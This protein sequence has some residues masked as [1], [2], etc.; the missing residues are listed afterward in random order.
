[1]N[2]RMI[3]YTVG[4]IAIVEAALMLLPAVVSLIYLEKSGFSFLITAAIALVLGFLLT[5]F[6]PK[7]TSIYAKE[8]FSIVAYAW[9]LM[10][11][12]GALP[13]VISGFVP[14]YID[15]FFETVSG[16]T[17]TGASILTDVEALDKGLLFWRSFT[18]WIGGMGV[19]VLVTA[20]V[21]NIG[22]RSINILK[23]EMPGPTVGKL[24]PRSRDTAKVLYIIYIALTFIQIIL[25]RVGGMP[26]YDSIVHTFGTAGTGG[27]GIKNNSIA[28]YSP[29]LQW[30]ITVFMLLFSINFNLYYLLLIRKF[31]TVFKSDELRFFLVMVL[32]CIAIVTVNIAP[33]YPSASEALRHSAFQVSSIVSTTGY[34]TTDFDL[35]PG[36]SKSILMLLMV[37]GACAGSTGGGLKA[38]RVVIL[39][40][41]VGRELQKLLHPRSVKTVSTEGKKLDDTTLNGVNSYFSI[42]IICIVVIYILLS[43]EPFD[44]ETN[45]SA[46]LACFNNIGPGLGKVGPTTNYAAY[47]GFSKILLSFAMLLGRLEIFPLLL[48]LNPFIWKSKRNKAF[49][50]NKTNK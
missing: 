38:A 34:A 3:F 2:R 23:A 16:F 10:S 43:F 5:R 27:F 12:L 1:M 25:L 36:L 44:M 42:Y 35:W 8:S 18:H 4:R 24:L 46:T 13:F 6:K 30:V 28:S 29:Y 47:S 20:V 21:S 49:K 50:I 45:F 9:L 11:L 33:L 22:D 37:V 41:S 7:D 26:L 39:L 48:G 31:K 14:S 40:K 15:A 19:L 17:T 32:C